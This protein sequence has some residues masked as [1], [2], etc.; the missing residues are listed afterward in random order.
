[1]L[2]WI[3]LAPLI[4]E[5]SLYFADLQQH[6]FECGSKCTVSELPGILVTYLVFY[7]KYKADAMASKEVVLT[8]ACQEMLKL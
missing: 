1:M 3:R 4:R 8:L 5:L 6:V 7:P 2:D